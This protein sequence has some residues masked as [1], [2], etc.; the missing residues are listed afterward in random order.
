MS[1][2]VGR[3]NT[4]GPLGRVS[5]DILTYRFDSVSGAVS[6]STGALRLYNDSGNDLAFGTI[7]ISAG[8]AP[9]GAALIGD[10]KLQ[11]TS[12]FATT[13]ANRPTI[14]ISGFTGTAGTPDTAVWPAGQYITF[15]VLQVGSSVAG[16][17]LTVTLATSP[18]IPS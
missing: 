10:I 15:D 17:N 8:T 14:A 16:S 1:G 18:A 7:R 6:T 12:I 4:A 5:Q 9:T 3:N 11:G 2:T 13:T